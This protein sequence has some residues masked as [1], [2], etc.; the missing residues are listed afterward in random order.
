[1]AVV[2]LAAGVMAAVK[3]EKTNNLTNIPFNLN[4]PGVCGKLA[5][6]GGLV[7]PDRVNFSQSPSKIWGRC[8]SGENR[9]GVAER[10]G[11]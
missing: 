6:P 2:H 1:M 11:P 3:K 8:Q 7:F 9:S 4:L 5:R 10:S